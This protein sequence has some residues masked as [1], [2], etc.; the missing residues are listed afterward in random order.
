MKKIVLAAMLILGVAFGAFCQGTGSSGPLDLVVLLDTSSSMSNF[1]RETSDYL[2]GP[3]LRE[4]LRIGDTFH[5]ISFGG[6]PRMEISRRIEG[7][8]D[9]ETVIARLLLMYPLDPNTDLAGALSFAERHIASLPGSRPAK[10]ILIS[11]G[12]SPMAQSVIS[13]ASSRLRARGVELQYIQV[14]VTG[15]GPVS[16][17]PRVAP[18]AVAQPP[19]PAR[20][21]VQPVP[22]QQAPP[23]QQLPVPG[24]QVPPPQQPAPGVQVV[25]PQQ[26]QQQQAGIQAPSAVPPQV[27]DPVTPPPQQQQEQAPGVERPADILAEAPGQQPGIETPVVAPPAA[28][29]VQAPPAQPPAQVPAQPPAAPRQDRQARSF[30][31]L[32]L[33]LLIA[34]GILALLLLALL[35]FLTA[36][37]LQSSPNRVMAQ[38]ASPDYSDRLQSQRD[39]QIKGAALIGSY[40]EAQRN[41]RKPLPRDKMYPEA[42]EAIDGGPLVL[43]LFVEDQNTAIGRRNIH[44]VKPGYTFSVGGGRSDFLIFLVP[45]PPH[46]ADIRSDGRNCTFIPRKPKYFPD[47]GSQQVSN[48][49]GKTIRVISDRNY[50]LFIR[51]ERYEDPLKKLNKILQSISVPGAVK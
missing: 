19:V 51:M 36:R 13:D 1:Y 39:E 49:I 33:P 14:P 17:R 45:L 26:Q 4:F 37:R 23:L 3:F 6:A 20:P 12:N 15:T 29:V 44:A 50:E 35:I 16:G 21:V 10:L 18:P 24:I 30:D 8:G 22:P 47:I 43:N 5:L 34:L 40:A 32:P 25:P 48:C 9:V 11:D 7:I 28:P 31:D 2:I 27:Q 41:T 42:G 46:I 38:A